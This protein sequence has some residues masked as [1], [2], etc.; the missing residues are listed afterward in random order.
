[1]FTLDYEL[2]F[3]SK[4]GTVGNCLIRP[5][6]ELLALFDKYRIR[7]T[8]F[9]D[10]LYYQ[11]LLDERRKQI[12][13]DED[14]RQIKKNLGAFISRG[15]ELQLHLHPHWIDAVLLGGA[16]SFPHYRNYRLQNLRR[17]K[18]LKD[19]R[20]LW[21]CVSVGKQRLEELGAELKS[22]GRV[23]AFRAGFWCLEPF[24]NLKEVLISND[25]S[26]DSSVAAGLFIKNGVHG[27]DFRDCPDKD[28]WSFE[29]AP[30][31]ET[32][33]GSFRE[34]PISTFKNSLFGKVSRRFGRI[35]SGASHN[36]KWGDG[37]GLPF[38]SR[39]WLQKLAPATTLMSFEGLAA[40]ELRAG[41][42]NLLERGHKRI[43]LIG[44]PKNMSP[45]SLNQ[46]EEFLKGLPSNDVEFSTLTEAAN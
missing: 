39:G 26:I 38:P 3:G 45:F 24:Q 46:T 5:G 25:I 30:Q 44:H 20:T 22:G 27:V 14:I 23:K 11:R 21:G 13:I 36:Q 28:G 33:G 10:V 31:Q 18:D 41:Y 6:E 4:S 2:F 35:S 19:I 17:D 42:R 29:D 12:W 8:I 15:H 32:D 1:M 34:I 37:E 40:S 9:F 7:S 43:T 16:W